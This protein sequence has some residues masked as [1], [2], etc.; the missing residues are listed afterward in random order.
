MVTKGHI[1]TGNIQIPVR[2]QVFE[3]RTSPVFGSSLYFECFDLCNYNSIKLPGH[4]GE[5]V[6][7]SF[8]QNPECNPSFEK[9]KNDALFIEQCTICL[10]VYDSEVSCHFTAASTID[11]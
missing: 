3:Y 9:W 11:G 1:I 8:L 2:G 4:P 5:K 7:F 10:S 6:F